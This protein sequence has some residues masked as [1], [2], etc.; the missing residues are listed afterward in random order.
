MC[1]REKLKYKMLDKG[2]YQGETKAYIKEEADKV[3]DAM[4]QRIKELDKRLEDVQNTM[5]TENV[6]LGMEN[7]KLK[8]RIKELEEEN[9]HL[10]DY[11]DAYQKSEA[12]NIEKLDKKDERIKELESDLSTMEVSYEA[13]IKNAVIVAKVTELQLQNRINE[14]EKQNDVLNAEYDLLKSA[15]EEK[16][17]E[18]EVVISKMETTAPKWISV[19]DRLPKE[20]NKRLVFED[21][22]GNLHCGFFQD[23][24]FANGQ[25]FYE[26]TKGHGEEFLISEVRRFYE[27]LPPPPSI[28]EK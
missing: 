5:A 6:D 7:F 12:L 1:G 13:L 2:G 21:H 9:K 18:L 11:I 4:E 16:I 25:I 10:E 3:M 24:A 28:E 8:Q 22:K 15:S 19:K 26:S 23:A 20:K 17:K 14:L 27:I